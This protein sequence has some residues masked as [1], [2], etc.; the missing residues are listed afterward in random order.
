MVLTIFLSGSQV[1][2]LRKETAEWSSDKYSPAG[3]PIGD[4]SS[5][6][7]KTFTD[8]RKKANMIRKWY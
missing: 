1:G 8:A 7:A 4:T 3:N 2:H 6:Q 5:T